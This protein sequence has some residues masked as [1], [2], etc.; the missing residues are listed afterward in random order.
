MNQ[1]TRRTAIASAVAVLALGCITP[2]FAQIQE[3]T[4][5]FATQNPKGHPINKVEDIA[6]LKLRVVIMRPRCKRSWPRSASKP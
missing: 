1:F 2:G 3:R 6:G 4:I 5:K